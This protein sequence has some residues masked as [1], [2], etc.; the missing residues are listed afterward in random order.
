MKAV[1]AVMISIVITVLVIFGLLQGSVCSATAAKNVTNYNSNDALLAQ[2]PNQ[3]IRFHVIA[4]SDSEEDQSL[5]R[6]VRDAILRE[7]SPKLAVSQSLEESRTIIKK[8]RPEMEDIGRS[9]V[10]SW[11]KDYTVHTE[12]GQFGFPTKSYGSL[13]LPAGN[14][15]AL[16]VV[17][18]KGQGSN[19]WCVLFPPLCFIDINH[20]TA[21][22]VDGKPGIPIKNNSTI[23]ARFYFW[24]L[25]N[26][27]SK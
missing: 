15:E 10:E 5:K 9:V 16:R 11:G 12:F 21:V 8:V 4:N 24:E 14:Y 17:I 6:A 13:V 27:L 26:K 2:T 18:G 1:R 19:W 22:Q 20:S 25:V 23:K 7:I 3:L